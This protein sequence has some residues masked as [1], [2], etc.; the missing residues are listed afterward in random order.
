LNSVLSDMGV[1]DLF[2]ALLL[3]SRNAIMGD[4]AY[5]TRGVNISPVYLL[6]CV[7][8]YVVGELRA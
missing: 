6:D 1:L 3:E 2:M 8:V 7:C 5:R 4:S